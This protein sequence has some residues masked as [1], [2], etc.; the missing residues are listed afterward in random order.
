M[1]ERDVP[2]IHGPDHAPGGP[3]PIPGGYAV[4][5]IK[6]FEDVN[7][8][9]VGDGRFLWPIPFDLDTASLI[10]VEAGVSTPS[11]SGPVEIQLR[12]L[13][14]GE[15]PGDALLTTKISIDVDL[16]NSKDSTIQP[17]IDGG[18]VMFDWGDW[19]AVDVDAAGTGATG[20]ALMATFIPVQL[21]QATLTGQQGPPGGVTDWEGGWTTATDYQEGDAVS[22]NGSSYVARVDH[23]S[24]A[25]SEPGVGVDWEDYWQI[26]SE[27]VPYSALELVLN[28]NGY[29]LE[30]GVKGWLTVPFD[31]SI[32]EATLLADLPGNLV[33]DI[34]KDTYGNFPPTDA[35]S[36][37][38][39][40][41]PTLTGATKTTNTTLS[42]WTTSL[43]VGDIL[44][45]N[46]D[47]CSAISRATLSLR[48]L[49]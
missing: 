13:E 49:K 40:S 7:V 26:L 42:G 2:P 12:R 39:A 41:P 27:G 31:C 19:V 28:G 38:S 23:N 29:V 47:S 35:D 21:A 1:T 37:T 16:F 22:R 46:V 44:A 3:D 9:A 8:V 5:E 18:A 15:G 33:I 14:Q 48:V 30:T 17:E 25:A 34:W 11:S 43:A 32:I 4:Y 6:I 24:S 36:I 20:L 10:R 45:F